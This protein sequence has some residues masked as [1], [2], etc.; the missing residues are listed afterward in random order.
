MKLA[1]VG[2]PTHP[3]SPKKVR[4]ST[5]PSPSCKS[6]PPPPPPPPPPVQDTFW[7]DSSQVFEPLPDNWERYAKA[8]ATLAGAFTL[9]ENE[10]RA[11]QPVPR[12]LGRDVNGLSERERPATRSQAAIGR[13]VDFSLRGSRKT[14]LRKY[15]VPMYVL[16]NASEDTLQKHVTGGGTKVLAHVNLRRIRIRFIWPQPPTMSASAAVYDEWV[17]IDESVTKVQLAMLVAKVFNGFVEQQKTGDL[18]RMHTSKWRL[19]PDALYRTWL[20]RLERVETK[21]FVADV[22]YALHDP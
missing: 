2:V 7:D 20:V 12:R 5:A 4:R 22:R 8:F 3:A 9:D 6:P 1:I 10:L 14:Y 18:S 16:L 13:K 19:R 15:G 17:R 11:L 21:V